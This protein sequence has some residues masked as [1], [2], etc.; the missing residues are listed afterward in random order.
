MPLC[1]R[2]SSIYIAPSNSAPF[3]HTGGA[4]YLRG[5]H[6]ADHLQTTSGRR[7]PAARCGG[8]RG[9]GAARWV[10]AARTHAVRVRWADWLRP[11]Q[12]EAARGRAPR[13]EDRQEPKA[14]GSARDIQV[15]AARTRRRGGAAAP[16]P[17]RAA[18]LLLA[19]ASRTCSGEGASE[20]ARLCTFESCDAMWFLVDR[21]HASARRRGGMVW[22]QTAPNGLLNIK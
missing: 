18:V 5:A 21:R 2:Y 4:L 1:L 19:L 11:S 3:A 22:D 12:A 6:R 10:V 15:T 8:E 13:Q 20:R 9:G 16:P 17:R 14:Q 7:P